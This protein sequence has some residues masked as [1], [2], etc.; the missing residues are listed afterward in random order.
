MDKKFNNCEEGEIT[1]GQIYLPEIKKLVKEI[2]ESCKDDKVTA[3]IDEPLIPDILQILNII[4][5]IV[6]LLYPGYFGE[7][8]LSYDILEYH[9]GSEIKEIFTEL[10]LQ[11]SRSLRHKCKRLSSICINCIKEGQKKSYEFIMKL[12]EL[13]SILKTDVIAAMEGDPAAKSYDEIVFSYPG[14]KAITY[15][16]IAHEL[17]NLEIPLI[18]RIINEHAHSLTGIDI[19]PGATIGPYFFID[20]GTGVVI[21]ETTV[22]GEHVRIYQ[23][24]TLGALSLPKETV[25]K[26]RWKK[27]HP[28]IEDNVIIYSGSTILGGRTVI[29]KNS[30]IGG[31]VWL[32]HS[33][34]ENSKVNTN[35]PETRK[36]A[37]NINSVSEFADFI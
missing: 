37:E 12:P 1:L 34:G 27:R 16:R 7:Q 19:H 4:N 6:D 18:P 10:A 36:K 35:Q 14:L 5:K 11:I 29:G 30:V 3:H 24:V 9:I 26:L 15:H 20:H 28:T 8:E 33:V 25:D 21:G 23:G 31:N 32:T 17:Y 22:I 2:V 13:R